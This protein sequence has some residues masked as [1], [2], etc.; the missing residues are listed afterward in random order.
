MRASWTS[1][2]RS[3]LHSLQGLKPCIRAHARVSHRKLAYMAHI[4]CLEHTQ[5]SS[6]K[7]FQLQC[8]RKKGSALVHTP[9]Q[10]RSYTAPCWTFAYR[11]LHH[12]PG[13]IPV[14]VTIRSGS[15]KNRRGERRPAKIRPS[16]GRC[17]AVRRRCRSA[18]T[19]LHEQSTLAT[20][21]ATDGR[22]KTRLA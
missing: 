11:L 21:R 7:A 14:P 12:G 4:C 16:K 3:L 6:M 8:L 2:I 18:V 22:H 10:G 13:R 15:S 5:S 9:T 20:L 1:A 19:H 17:W